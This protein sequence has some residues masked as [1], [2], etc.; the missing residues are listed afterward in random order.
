MSSS[1]QAGLVAPPFGRQ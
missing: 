1:R